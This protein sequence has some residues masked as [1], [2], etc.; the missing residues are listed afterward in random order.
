MKNLLFILMVFEVIPTIAQT[1]NSSNEIK[2]DHSFI[3]NLFP[4]K[5]V[6]QTNIIQ[7]HDYLWW[8]IFHVN[9]TVSDK[10]NHVLGCK[11]SLFNIILPKIVWSVLNNT[12]TTTVNTSCPTLPLKPITKKLQ[13]LILK[14]KR[15]LLI[16]TISSFQLLTT[17][18]LLSRKTFYV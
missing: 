4:R 8:L 14:Q 7:V 11:P 13:N 2:R 6:G 5:R 9:H 16:G 3:V 1:G 10:V 17:I 18:C 15:F 12:C